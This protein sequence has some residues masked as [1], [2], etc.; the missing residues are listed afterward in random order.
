MSRTA[1][2]FVLVVSLGLPSFLTAIA[3]QD[4]EAVK[5]RQKEI[6]KKEFKGRLP[7]HYGQIVNNAQR[8]R[9]YQ[10]QA[11]YNPQIEALRAEIEALTAKRDAEILAVLSPDQQQRLET[12]VNGAKA[13][14][15]AKAAQK[16]K[17]NE[18]QK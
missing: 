8:Q 17:A 11:T 4:V 9:I 5:I 6:K 15:A 18:K 1:L 10:I 7:A 14:R 2:A 13:T 16:K 12:L 3:Q